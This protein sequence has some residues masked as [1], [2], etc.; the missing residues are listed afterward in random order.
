MV[1]ASALRT[2]KNENTKISRKNWVFRDKM[3]INL[4]KP[5]R[6]LQEK[7]DALSFFDKE[8]VCTVY[9][10][11]TINYGYINVMTPKFY[12]FGGNGFW[13]FQSEALEIWESLKQAIILILTP[14]INGIIWS[15][16]FMRPKLIFSNKIQCICTFAWFEME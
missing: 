7:T 12:Y 16:I 9:T 3:S 10:L 2:M 5:G 11:C 6:S 15:I 8:F 14:N 13:K 1:H 4:D